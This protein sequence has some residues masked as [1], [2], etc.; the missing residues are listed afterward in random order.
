MPYGETLIRTQIKTLI[1]TLIFSEHGTHG[2]NGIF[3]SLR[4]FRVRNKSLCLCASAC[5]NYNMEISLRRMSL[6][7]LLLS[8]QFTFQK[9]NHRKVHFCVLRF[10]HFY[11]IPFSLT[12]SFKS[13]LSSSLVLPSLY[14]RS[15]FATNSLQSRSLE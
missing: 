6:C 11:H 2:R 3:R 10:S 14:L 9:I 12:S 1:L 7:N 15:S 4:V 5:L 8:W 13:S